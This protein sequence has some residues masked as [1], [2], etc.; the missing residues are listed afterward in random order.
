MPPR[1]LSTRRCAGPFAYYKTIA[2]CNEQCIVRYQIAEEALFPV[3][4]PGLSAERGSLQLELL[5]PL[6]GQRGHVGRPRCHDV[7]LGAQEV[8]HQLEWPASS[9]PHVG[10]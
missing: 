9:A 6:R 7:A 1:N 3:V 8:E 5:R 4:P 2:K 10:H